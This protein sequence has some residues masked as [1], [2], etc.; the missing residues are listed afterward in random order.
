MAPRLGGSSRLMRE[1]LRSLNRPW[2]LAVLAAAS[3]LLAMRAA[4]AAGVLLGLGWFLLLA[5]RFD[6]HTGSCFMI[7]LLVVIVVAT[8]AMLVGFLALFAR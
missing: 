1:L 8:L 3:V 6:N 2:P 4:P 7:A 5:A